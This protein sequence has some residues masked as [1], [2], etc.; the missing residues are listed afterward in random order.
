MLSRRVLN[1]VPPLP[2]LITGIT[3]VAGFQAFRYFQRRFPGQVLA[4]RQANNWPLTGEGIIACDAEDGPGLD[5]LFAEHNFQSVLNCAGNCALKKCE[6][7]P[8]LAWRLNLLG[9]RTMLEVMANRP[10]LRL[11]HLS[12]DLVFSGRGQGNHLEHDVTDPVTVYGQSMA[13][14]EQ[15]VTLA[16]PDACI[17]RISLPM[18]AV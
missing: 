2:L 17:L 10:Q 12:I 13:A 11:V 16:K 14:A 8:D 5:R 1:D 9:L 6:L 15:L 3:G 4:I 18:G 7:D